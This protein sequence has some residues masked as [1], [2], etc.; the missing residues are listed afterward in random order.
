M[1][2]GA[3]GADVV[4]MVVRQG[5]QPVLLGMVIGVGVAYSA[6]RVLAAYVHGVTTSDPLTFAAV[7]G[8]L[9]VVAIV[10]TAL[11]AR[12]AVRIAPSAALRL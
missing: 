2:L 1:A 12:Q 10:A 8:L 6:S 5:M 9:T 7:I 3:R 4:R 11:P